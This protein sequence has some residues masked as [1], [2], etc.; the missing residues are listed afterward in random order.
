MIKVWQ[1]QGW[2]WIGGMV[3][4][5]SHGNSARC[6]ALRGQRATGSAHMGTC[7]Q[8]IG[9]SYWSRAGHSSSLIGWDKALSFPSSEGAF[10]AHATRAHC[11]IAKPVW[12]SF[13]FQGTLMMMSSLRNHTWCYPFNQCP[14]EH[15][16]HQRHHCDYDYDCDDHHHCHPD[17]HDDVYNYEAC[18]IQP[19]IQFG[20]WSK[21]KCRKMQHDKVGSHDCEQLVDDD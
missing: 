6:S 8:Q 17:H 21:W 2:L 7:R 3:W 5:N 4:G 12:H 16:C 9:L 13:K 1:R 10:R 11:L 15:Q 19:L 14:Q 18:G 20:A